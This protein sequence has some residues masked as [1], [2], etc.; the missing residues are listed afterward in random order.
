MI[1]INNKILDEKTTIK[2]QD[3]DKNNLINNEND[4]NN[5]YQKIITQAYVH[6]EKANEEN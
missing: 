6:F 4:S 1:K 3:V 5:P 2:E